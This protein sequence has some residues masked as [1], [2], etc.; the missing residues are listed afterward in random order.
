MSDGQTEQENLETLRRLL[1]AL[2]RWLP[3][4]QQPPAP[5][6]SGSQFAS[7]D[8]LLNPVQI[9]HAAWSAILLAVDHLHNLRRSVEGCPSCQPGATFLNGSNYSLLRGALEN[10]S[11]AV[12]LLA[13]EDQ[14]TRIL[15]RLQLEVKHIQDQEKF[16]T[17]VKIPPPSREKAERLA[18]IKRLAA[19][20]GLPGDG[21][22]GNP[23]PTRMVR[24]AGE[25]IFGDADLG[26]ILWSLCS[27]AAH[28]DPWATLSLAEKTEV[29]RKANVATI[30]LSPSIPNLL[31]L[32]AAAVEVIQR[33][34]ILYAKRNN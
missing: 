19:A 22:I 2:D 21:P 4:T 28:G 14:K 34:F 8:T 6:G 24:A 11:K 31:A 13:P 10:A 15:R 20:A 25:V 23:S 26:Q 5:V 27:G 9:S 7:D 17:L 33:A 29:A 16:Q 12:W 1:E 18:E 30:H 32:T 3:L